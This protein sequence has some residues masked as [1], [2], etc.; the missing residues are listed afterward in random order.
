MILTGKMDGTE[1][2]PNEILEQGLESVP[3]ALKR[4]KELG[5]GERFIVELKRQVTVAP[6]PIAQGV[7][8]K[9]EVV[10]GATRKP[11]SDETKAAAAEKRAKTRAA[12][13]KAAK[14]ASEKPRKRASAA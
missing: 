14:N 4:V 6:P 1:F 2:V 11:M 13:Q 3:A 12:N 7:Q 10:F 9:D 5:E 8:L